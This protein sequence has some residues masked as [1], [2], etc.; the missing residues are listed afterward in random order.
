MRRLIGAAVVLALAGAAAGQDKKDG[1]FDPKKLVGRWESADPKRAVAV[2][3][4]EK[5]KFTLTVAVGGK[6][7]KV[8]GT[9]KLTGDKLELA[10][11]VGDADRKETVTLSKLT[12]DDLVGTGS[13]GKEEA[14]RR[15][16]PKK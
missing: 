9:W 14:Y 5:D 7:E 10:A 11:K 15:V 4:L 16:K 6:T 2:E 13:D 12:D 3:F 1:P 8:D